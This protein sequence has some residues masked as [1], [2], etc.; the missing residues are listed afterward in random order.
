M[1]KNMYDI[2]PLVSSRLAVWPGD[3]PYLRTEHL[4][5]EKG[6]NL[7]L[8]S[9]EGTLHLG[10][11]ADAPNHYHPQGVGIDQRDL[12]LYLGRTQVMEVAAGEGRILPEHLKQKITAKRVLF[13]TKS[14]PDPEKFN[15]DFRS[16]SV[17][18]VKYLKSEG[19]ILVG[20][21]TPSVD[22]KNSKAL[23]AHNEIYRSNM[24]ILEGVVLDEVPEGHYTLIALPLKLEGADASPVRAVLLSS[25]DPLKN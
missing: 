14:Y 2:T 5:F 24:A 16:L 10:A 25:I 13:R 1:A 8:S 21:D 17:E 4:S 11:H 9:M 15:D 3:T 18:L 6:D 7:L 23:E 19:V 22:P 12:S 20:I